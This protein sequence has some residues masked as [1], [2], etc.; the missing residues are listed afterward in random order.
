[1]TLRG[2]LQNAHHWLTAAPA[3]QT[4]APDPYAL[5]LKASQAAAASFR[6]LHNIEHYPPRE[7]TALMAAAKTN[8]IVR[9]ALKLTSEAVATL[10][11]DVHVAGQI[12]DPDEN[13]K[14]APLARVLDRPNPDQDFSGFIA[15]L[16]SFYKASG[17]GWVE[18]V[19]GFTDAY[20]EFY[21]LRPDRMHIKPGANG[22]P[23]EYV[24]QATTGLKKSWR[25][26]IQ[27][28]RRDILHIKDE[29]LDDD[30]FGH[31][32]LEAADKPLRVYD[33]AYELA[34]AQFQNGAAP[35]GA[36]VWDPSVPPG[37]T[38]PTLTVEQ[39]QEFEARVNQKFRGPKN[40][41]KFA[42][43]SGGWRFEQVGMTMV[44]L[45]AMEIRFAAARDIAQAFGVPSL[46]LGIPGDNTYANFSEASRAFYRSTVLADARRIYGAL[47]RW[48][49]QL[50]GVPIELIV[51]EEKIW[52]LAD[53]LTLQW[54]RTLGAEVLTL[55]EKREAL[56]YDPV[57]PAGQ[58]L[59]MGAGL[60]P[61][62]QILMSD[63]AAIEPPRKARI[64][65]DENEG[66]E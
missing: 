57:P 48:F 53:E 64:V 52:A 23:A 1:M 19:T 47:G 58:T 24:F 31:G 55:E 26:D 60:A 34:N 14:L 50:F 7:Y 2:F 18:R 25:V 35:A 40:R 9:R 8:P 63:Y 11:P 29:A 43:F 3:S 41:G 28:E 38:Q 13:S 4:K 6:Y 10:R 62:E 17:N 30:L 44:D 42:V 65:D 16:A 33:A 56:G 37:A 54:Q 59:L 22:W 39:Q 36:F 61:L 20:Q 51:D 21:A 46:M 45:Q 5:Q 49:T 32:A 12:V 27:N 66:D 15:K